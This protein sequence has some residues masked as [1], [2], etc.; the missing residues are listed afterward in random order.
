MSGSQLFF[1]A[2]EPRISNQQPS[3][4]L[5]W[6]L[7]SGFMADFFLTYR[8]FMSPVQLCKYLIQRYLWALEEDTEFRCVIR[9]R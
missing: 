2:N 9:V 5:L 6:F 7:D 3:Y 1:F 4:F 8:L